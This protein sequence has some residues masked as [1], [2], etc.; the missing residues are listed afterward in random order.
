MANQLS[1]EYSGSCMLQCKLP[2]LAARNLRCPHTHIHDYCKPSRA[3]PARSELVNE[4]KID[5]CSVW[6]SRSLRR[7]LRMESFYLEPTVHCDMGS[8]NMPPRGRAV[9]FPR[10]SGMRALEV[11]IKA[12]R[13]EFQQHRNKFET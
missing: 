13:L 10:S 1:S 9:R 2:V 7:W 6:I 11:I 12:V 5:Y 3:A 4:P 8:A